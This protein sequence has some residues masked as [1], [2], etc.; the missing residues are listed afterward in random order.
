VQRELGLGS[1]PEDHSA[2]R[3]ETLDEREQAG[4]C[5][6][7]EVEVVDDEHNGLTQVG[8]VVDDG[9][10]NVVEIEFPL[11][12]QVGH[13]EPA[14]GPHMSQCR[15]EREPERGGIRI[16]RVAGQPDRRQL[17]AIVQPGLE[18]HALAR[19]G[20]TD[21]DRQRQLRSSVERRMKTRARNVVAR[22]R[23]HRELRR[24][25]ESRRHGSLIAGRGVGN[26]VPSLRAW[27]RCRKGPYGPRRYSADGITLNGVIPY[28]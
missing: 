15:N 27:A 18:H 7:G 26:H 4:C 14:V 3:R 19:A 22:K 21:D 11:R 16:K 1:T 6:R 28:Q 13:V 17:E 12:E 8:Q 24:R 5:G 25:E 10:R 23:R 20:H 2:A 9:N